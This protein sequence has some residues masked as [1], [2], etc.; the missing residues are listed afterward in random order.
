MNWWD[1]HTYQ[2]DGRY[3]FNLYKEELNAKYYVYVPGDESQSLRLDNLLSMPVKSSEEG[4]EI[5]YEVKYLILFT[6][7]ANN[8]RPEMAFTENT[9]RGFVYLPY[10][11]EVW[12]EYET[13]YQIAEEYTGD[14]M[15]YP[16]LAARNG[17]ENPD[18]IRKGQKL[19][20]PEEWL[21]SEW[22]LYYDL[23]LY[24]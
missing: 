8:Y 23:A 12:S 1:H 16:E 24:R 6:S 2:E 18:L 17:L 15:R 21:I 13:L 5:R 19:T 9:L 14:G 7:W 3:F 11:K 10:Q 4:E 22:F 20:V